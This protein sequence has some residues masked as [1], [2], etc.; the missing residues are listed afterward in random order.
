M[1]KEASQPDPLHAIAAVE[2]STGLSKDTLRI[3]ERRYGFPTPERDVN[4]ERVYAQAQVDRLRLI[5]RLMDLGHRPGRLMPLSLDALTALGAPPA[6]RELPPE[7]AVF[8]DV[9]RAHDVERLRAYLS[10]LV[11]RSGLEQF[12][13]RTMP[14]LNAAVGDAWARGELAIFEEHLYSHHVQTLL[15]AAISQLRTPRDGPCVVLTSL[16]GEPH[17]L[18]LLM[19]EVLFAIEGALC[20]PLG[21]ETPAPEVVQAAAAHRAQIVAL[22]F[23]A[24]FPVSTVKDALVELRSLLPE[25]VELWAG[26]AGAG[27]GRRVPPR[28]H[29]LASLED[30]VKLLRERITN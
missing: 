15:R 11:V 7:T 8:L 17:A 19:T 24:A 10:E 27:R 6:E 30:G 2:R 22:S 1:I 16:P 9:L 13:L 23:S 14:I 3:W 21:T 29:A 28:V 20:V 25:A 5:K 12:V 18:G 4:G 26:G